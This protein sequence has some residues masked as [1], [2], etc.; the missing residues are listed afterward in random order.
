MLGTCLFVFAAREVL[1][2][3][4]FYVEECLYQICIGYS[5]EYLFLCRTVELSEALL[6]FK[7]NMCLK[8]ALV[9]QV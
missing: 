6:T 7:F 5:I 4:L 2:V 9:G 3:H 1:N 8:D